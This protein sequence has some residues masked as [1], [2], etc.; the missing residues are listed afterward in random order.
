[1]DKKII[2]VSAG[3]EITEEEFNQFV[4]RI[5]QEQQQYIATPEGRQQALTQYA[6]YFLFE[7]LGEEKKYDQSEEFLAIMDGARRELLSQYALTQEVQDIHATEEECRAYYEEHKA[8]FKKE[9]QA[10][11][12]HILTATEE[13]CQKVLAEIQNGEKTFAEAAKAYSTCPSAAQGG[14]LG[15]F[16]R[17]QMVKEFDEAVFTAE[18]GK[19]LGPVKTTYGYHLIVV[20][21]LK[22]GEEASFED[23]AQQIAQQITNQKQNER[24]MAVRAELIEKYGLEFK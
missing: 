17:G 3:K 4:A 8:S 9:A 24:Y 10:T 19:I 14:A 16:G 23:V 21:E 22:G 2:A 13:E 5:P 11:A 1:M 18:V 12:R 20:E 15:T 6:N 7:K